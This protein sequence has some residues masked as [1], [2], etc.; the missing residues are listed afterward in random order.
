[1]KNS[2][3]STGIVFS[4]LVLGLTV[5]NPVNAYK[6]MGVYSGGLHHVHRYKRNHYGKRY[7]RGKNRRHRYGKRYSYGYKH[8]PYY[9]KYGYGSYGGYFGKPYKKHRYK[10]KRHYYGKGY[11]LGYQGNGRYYG[12]K[13]FCHPVSKYIY[14]DYGNRNKIGGTMCYDQYGQGYVVEGSRYKIW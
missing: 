7:S 9:R 11:G 10:Y 5:A 8:K 3:L 14:D 4:I 13:K 6:K 2:I 1:M 12:R